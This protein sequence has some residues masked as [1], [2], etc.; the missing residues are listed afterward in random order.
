[1]L[2]RTGIFSDPWIILYMEHMGYVMNDWKPQLIGRWRYFVLDL[3]DAG[4]DWWWMDWTSYSNPIDWY[5]WIR[6]VDACKQYKI[7][8]QMVV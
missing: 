5:A 2:H 1:M 4:N 8:P 7:F 3:V 6:L